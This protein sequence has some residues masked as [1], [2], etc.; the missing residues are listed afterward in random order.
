MTQAF[1]LSWPAGW[2]RIQASWRKSTYRFSGLTPDRARSSLIKEVQLLGDQHLVIS[3]NLPTNSAGVPRLDAARYKIDD[4][5]VA[6]YF[7]L[8][9][10]EIS[11]AQDLYD[12]VYGNM[13]SLALAIEAMRALE[14]HGGGHMM[15]KSF[16]GFAALPPPDGSTPATSRPWRQVLSIDVGTEIGADM[17]EAY[18][19]LAERRY[20]ALARTAH[21]DHG[22][23]TEAMAELTAAIE[24]CR[25]ELGGGK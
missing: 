12:A 22:G 16:D 3:S 2:P 1:P 24:A 15:R 7:V 4:P 18:L 17:R 14:R 25:A 5:G 8:D 13:R 19:L 9:D 11:M 23:S 20:K 6:I 10:R 21:P